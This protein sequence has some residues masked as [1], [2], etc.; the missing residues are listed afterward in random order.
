MREKQWIRLDKT[1]NLCYK[2]SRL[3]GSHGRI[4]FLGNF[5]NPLIF[6]K[7]NIASWFFLRIGLL[8]LTEAFHP[9]EQR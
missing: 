4:A 3:W 2:P 5:C 7:I 6:M 1:R 9:F 8:A